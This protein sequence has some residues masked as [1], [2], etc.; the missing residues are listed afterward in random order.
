M[1]RRELPFVIRWARAVATQHED[2]GWE[3]IGGLGNDALA[4]AAEAQRDRTN[5]KQ[6]RLSPNVWGLSYVKR[7]LV[8]ACG[9]HVLSVST[10]QR[11]I[12]LLKAWEA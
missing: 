12:D 6:L 7:A 1:S 4:K 8:W 9:W 11:L 5:A 3:H 10:T 2:R